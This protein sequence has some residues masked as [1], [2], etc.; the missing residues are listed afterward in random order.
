MQDNSLNNESFLFH[1][2]IV[3]TSQP[4]A[5]LGQKVPTEHLN[6]HLKRALCCKENIE[7]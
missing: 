6:G 5:S 2:A 7:E 1:K 3:L 4:F